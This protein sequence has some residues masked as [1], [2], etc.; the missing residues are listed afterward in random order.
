MLNV[1]AEPTCTVAVVG[2]AVEHDAKVAVRAT[3]AIAL[4]SWGTLPHRT[5]LGQLACSDG[6]ERLPA[7]VLAL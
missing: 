1:S 7:V 5:A 6:R 2:G 4:V 3:A